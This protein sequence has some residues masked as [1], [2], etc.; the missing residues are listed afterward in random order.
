[1]SLKLDIYPPILNEEDESSGVILVLQ[2]L[3]IDK[4]KYV[5]IASELSQDKFWVIVPNCFP[6]GRNYLCPDESSVAKVLSSLD[7]SKFQA[8]EKALQRG[9]VL[10]GHSAGGI[11]AFRSNEANSSELPYKLIAIVTYGSNA[12]SNNKITSPLPPLLMLS[13]EK[14]SVITSEIS[15]TAFERISA[16]TKTFIE[17]AGL[18]HYSINDSPQPIGPP[19]EDNIADF[20]NQD[21]VRLISSVVSSFV[22]SV[23]AQQENWLSCLDQD[24]VEAIVYSEYKC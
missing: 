20:S 1:M 15:R 2:G 7:F 11:A 19:T 23:Q 5:A 6:A 10:L 13:G 16:S 22:R 8:L 14:D 4:S 18:N 12:P 17:L 24:I 21:S 9:V 3:E